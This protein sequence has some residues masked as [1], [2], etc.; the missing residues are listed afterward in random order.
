MP[1]IE[2]AISTVRQSV[3][4]LVAISDTGKKKKGQALFKMGIGTAWCIV[5]NRYFQTRG[6][7]LQQGDGSWII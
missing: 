2:S 5:A 1:D 4:A 6:V 3:C 7:R